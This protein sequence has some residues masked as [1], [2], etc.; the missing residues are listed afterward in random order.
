[1]ITNDPTNDDDLVAAAFA[2]GRFSLVIDPEGPLGRLAGPAWNFAGGAQIHDP[3]TA[4]RFVHVMSR[5]AR[6]EIRGYVITMADQV[7]RLRG[8]CYAGRWPALDRVVQ[9]QLRQQGIVTTAILA[10]VDANGRVRDT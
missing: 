3:R 7:L 4:V 2:D 10:D 9:A 5:A 1:M 6:G 8:P